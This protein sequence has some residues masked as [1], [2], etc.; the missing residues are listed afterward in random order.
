[1][2]ALGDRMKMYEAAECGRTFMPLLPIYARIDGRCFSRFTHGM[3]RP[4]DERLSRAMVQTTKALVEE[5]HAVIGYTQ[6]DEISLAWLQAGPDSQMLFGGKVHKLNSVLASFTAAVFGKRCFDDEHLHDFAARH[7]PHFDARVFQLPNVDE[8]ANA[9][10]WREQDA[11]KNA[12]SMA[13]RSVYSHKALDGKSGPEMQE[14]LFERGIN[15]NDYPA[16]F[17]RG[18]FVRRKAVS[19]VLTG[20]E[21][22]RIPEKHRPEPE[23]L[24]TRT[25]TV[26]L[27]MPK[28]SSVTN[29]VAVIFEGAAPIVAAK[30]A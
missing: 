15:F 23:A 10:L 16:F 26:E 4:Y 21:I 29:R 12:V 30:A 18:T 11:T 28:F 9:F 1:M 8:A 13:A 24:V 17:K 25:E 2:D 7:A 3:D 5:F 6:S 27:D 14:M 19:R 20:M 22:E